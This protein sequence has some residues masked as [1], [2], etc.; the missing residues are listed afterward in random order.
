MSTEQKMVTADGVKVSPGDKVWDRNANECVINSKHPGHYY[1]SSIESGDASPINA[2]YISYFKACK[3]NMD[4]RWR[5]YLAA[6]ERHEAARLKYHA[7]V[8]DRLGSD[9]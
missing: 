6:G 7:A 2:C 3:F 4:C 1:A 5:E 8:T 9:K